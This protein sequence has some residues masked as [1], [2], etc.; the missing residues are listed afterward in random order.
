[1]TVTQEE[2]TPT[3]E[4]DKPT[5]TANVAA[6]T[7]S[8]SVT[9]NTTWTATVN[10]AAT[11]CTLTNADATGNGVVKVSITANAATVTR[12]ATVTVSAGALTAQVDVT[13]EGAPFVVYEDDNV[14]THAAS[15][16]VWQ[17]GSSTLTW[18]DAIQIPECNKL[19]FSDS[20]TSPQ[21]R[22][23]TY[24]GKTYY[25]YNWPYVN[26]HAATLCPA[27]WRVPAPSDFR[28]L[29]D[30]SVPDEALTAAW[31][32]GGSVLGSSVSAVGEETNSWTNA[33]YHSSYAECLG[34]TSA[35]LNVSPTT[36]NYGFEVVCVK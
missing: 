14:P 21:C 19:S 16:Y 36:K 6:A 3:L 2:A 24:E 10:S 17:F 15:S 35:G 25:Y 33:E 11:W 7:Y 23:Y 28:K 30:A 1:V 31:L 29:L 9:S 4:A 27:P 26:Q 20:D 32:S 34:P 22:S 5:I 8:I 18:S 12:A 13:Q